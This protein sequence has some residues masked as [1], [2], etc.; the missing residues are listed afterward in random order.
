[1]DGS[2]PEREMMSGDMTN[3]GLR[4]RNNRGHRAVGHKGLTTRHR[5]TDTRTSP[6]FRRQ[7]WAYCSR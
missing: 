4:N 2:P 3:P 5:D 1:V 6:V 7:A